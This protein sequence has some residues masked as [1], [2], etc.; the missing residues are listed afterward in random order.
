MVQVS[1]H[2]PNGEYYRS[3]GHITGATVFKNG[4]WQDIDEEEMLSHDFSLYSDL[5][6]KSED[7]NYSVRSELLGAIL[8]EKEN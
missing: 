8:I 1:V 4:R 3:F 2:K 5:R 7:R 6:L